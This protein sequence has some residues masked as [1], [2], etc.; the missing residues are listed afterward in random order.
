MNKIIIAG[1]NGFLARYL[2]RYFH[3]KGWQVAGLARRT[4]GLD[5]HCRYIHWDGGTL[6]DWAGELDGCEV[7]VN[8]TGRSVNCRYNDK[9]KAEIISSRVNSTRV[10]GEAIAACENP[11]GV[12]MNASTATIYRH[13]EDQPQGEQG[14]LGEGF[15]VEVAKAWEGA[16]FG[17]KVPGKVRKVALRTSLVMA[18]EPG[19]VFDY[20][21]KLSRLFLGGPVGGG[22]GQ[23]AE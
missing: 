21:Y 17:A 18:N 3:N 11:P 9:N 8:M 23:H 14:E 5:E 6:G 19:T 13:S 20:L 1:A 10:L 22:G 15:S 4:E 7:L 16:F 2:S 12:W